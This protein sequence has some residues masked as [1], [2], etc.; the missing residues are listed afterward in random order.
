MPDFTFELPRILGKARAS[1]GP[2]L[3]AGAPF[4]GSSGTAFATASIGS[5]AAHGFGAGSSALKLPDSPKS[6]P[7]AAGFGFGICPGA[8]QL[9]GSS[10]AGNTHADGLGGGDSAAVAACVTPTGPSISGSR[11]R[12]CFGLAAAVPPA[13][14]TAAGNTLGTTAG[15]GCGVGTGGR[16]GVADTSPNPFARFAAV[17]GPTWPEGNAPFGGGTA[18]L[19]PAVG[20]GVG[21]SS[22]ALGSASGGSGL[23]AGFVP[24]PGFAA[25]AAPAFPASAAG[26]GGSAPSTSPTRIVRDLG[27]SVGQVG[28]GAAGGGF[29]GGI[30]GPDGCI[31]PDAGLPMGLALRSGVSDVDM[32]GVSA[33]STGEKY[34]LY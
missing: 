23:A 2:A 18:P 20:A 4:G 34:F 25:T 13:I 5:N 6:G 14:S 16:F 29:A 24:S 27:L 31:T 22:G 26:G 11:P 9:G 10:V 33:L 7:P 28:S 3:G 30:S 21:G 32:A 8:G 17:T 19:S 15:S 1:P 12:F